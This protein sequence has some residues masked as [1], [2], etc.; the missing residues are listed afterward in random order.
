MSKTIEQMKDDA[1]ASGFTSGWDKAGETVARLTEKLAAKNAQL[2]S[3]VSKELEAER[4]EVE[5]LKRRIA[6]LEPDTNE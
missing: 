4:A 5:E 6:Q 2:A 1:Y 3:G